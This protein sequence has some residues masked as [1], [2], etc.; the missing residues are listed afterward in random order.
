VFR[1]AKLLKGDSKVRDWPPCQLRPVVDRWYALAVKTVGDIDADVDEN[2]FDF[3]E[4]WERVRFPGKGGLMTTLLETLRQTE[5]SSTAQRYAPGKI[6][7]LV[8]LCRELQ[9]RADA[10]PFFLAT[11]T[12]QEIFGLDHRMRAWKWLRGLCKD[13]VLEIEKVGGPEGRKASTYRYLG[14]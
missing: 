6:R 2:W 7:E 5:P 1:L 12:V 10:A 9:Q 14:K 8:M 4:G 11:S 3:Q 13:G